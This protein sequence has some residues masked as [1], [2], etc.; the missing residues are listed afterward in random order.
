MKKTGFFIAVFAVTLFIFSGISEAREKYLPMKVGSMWVYTNGT[1]TDVI[2]VD[3]EVIISGKLYYKMINK[4]MPSGR[5]TQSYLRYDKD[6]L[7][8][9]FD[10]T[11][12]DKGE[13]LIKTFPFIAGASGS[14]TNKDNKVVKW[15]V[16]PSGTIS[17][18]NQQYDNCLKMTM[19][20]YDTN[21][22]LPVTIIDYFAPN[23]GSIKKITI[24]KTKL[25]EGEVMPA[26]SELI[27]Y[28]P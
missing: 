18:T 7:Y 28:K 8:T 6:G 25:H 2:T 11:K 24:I 23:V 12:P 27:K 22:N 10:S 9:F 19:D 17:I 16:E 4:S 15:R 21:G 1:S 14:F 3:S 20:L 13:I 5:T 26:E